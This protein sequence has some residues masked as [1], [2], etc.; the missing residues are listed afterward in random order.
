MVRSV[1]FPFTAVL[2][3]TFISF[4]CGNLFVMMLLI[5]YC[6]DCANRLFSTFPGAVFPNITIFEIVPRSSFAIILLSSIISFSFANFAPLSL[7]SSLSIVLFN[8]K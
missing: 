4:S 2:S 6:L 3:S 5:S 8:G 7:K 1:S